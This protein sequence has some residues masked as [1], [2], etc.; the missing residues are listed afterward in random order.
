MN[1]SKSSHFK[2]SI[3]FFH[4][5]KNLCLVIVIFVLLSGIA[6]YFSVTHERTFRN[7]EMYFRNINKKFRKPIESLSVNSDYI[8]TRS[9]EKAPND[10]PLHIEHIKLLKSENN[11]CSNDS[12]YSECINSAALFH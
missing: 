12:T 3:N 7:I 6:K 4:A 2:K 10:K 8:Q 9:S 5:P 11:D 1:K